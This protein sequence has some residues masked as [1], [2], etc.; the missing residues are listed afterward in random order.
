MPIIFWAKKQLLNLITIGWL[1]IKEF[2]ADSFMDSAR[3]WL[4]NWRP[5]VVVWDFLYAHPVFIIVIVFASIT[6]WGYLEQRH[7]SRAPIPIPNRD[8]LFR[9][10]AEVKIAALEVDE[11]IQDLRRQEQGNVIFLNPERWGQL[12]RIRGRFKYACESLQREIFAAGSV[13]EPILKPLDLCMQS[14]IMFD[15][16]AIGQLIELATETRNKID[17]LSQPIP[18][19]G[20]SQTE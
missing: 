15:S 16:L 19:K 6:L 11:N 13:V 5:A 10:I 1:F 4:A 8:A 17:E 2:T 20:G 12:D 14:A 18:Y 3:N 7:K 9:A